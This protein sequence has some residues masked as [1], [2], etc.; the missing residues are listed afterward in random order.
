M[1]AQHDCG[2]LC[3]STAAIVSGSFIPGVSSDDCDDDEDGEGD[4]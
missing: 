4:D 2:V 1:T 3:A